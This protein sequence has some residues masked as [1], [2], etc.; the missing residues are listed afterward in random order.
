MTEASEPW[1]PV[2][3]PW[4]YHAAWTLCQG[5]VDRAVRDEL[6][7]VRRAAR[8]FEQPDA[9]EIS[10]EEEDREAEANAHYRWPTEYRS[11]LD[12]VATAA[13]R[14]SNEIETSTTGRGKGDRPL[15]GLLGLGF[16]LV[17]SLRLSRD[18]DERDLQLWSHRADLRGDIRTLLF[19]FGRD[20]LDRAVSD[21]L[22]LPYRCAY[23]DRLLVDVLVAIECYA[24]GWHLKSWGVGR[25]FPS[26]T[27]VITWIGVVFLAGLGFT[28]VRDVFGFRGGLS[29]EIA[30]VVVVIS[31]LTLASGLASRFPRLTDPDGWLL[32]ELLRCYR[33]LDAGSPV[34]AR[35]LIERLQRTS[36][37]GAVWPPP[38]H[39][40]LDD[41]MARGGRIG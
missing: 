19:P 26:R 11:A 7:R 20:E 28:L 8:R 31:A 33:E 24:F 10:E 39:A 9:G 2:S 22:H 30:Y 36:D 15:R 25:W 3:D 40:L 37:L 23:L 29:T 35:H 14:Y 34:S 17:Q 38:L 6:V 5:A 41:V 18:R 13:L 4:D 32:T 21:Y 1:D 16:D 27:T 12:A